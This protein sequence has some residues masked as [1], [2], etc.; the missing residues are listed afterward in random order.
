VPRWR[1]CKRL[2]GGFA[3]FAIAF[4]FSLGALEGLAMRGLNMKQSVQDVAFKLLVDGPDS[5]L[6]KHS[7]TAE[8][9]LNY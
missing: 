8:V 5:E 9:L 6:S 3:F 2:G 4:P 7:L 1:V